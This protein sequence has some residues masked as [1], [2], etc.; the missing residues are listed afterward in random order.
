[1]K[2]TTPLRRRLRI[3]AI[4]AVA[5][6]PLAFAGLYVAA[7]GNASSGVSDIPAAVVNQDTMVTTTGTD[8]SPQYT[9]A[10]RAL[11]TQL[12][13][14][15]SPGMDWTIT[16]A[17]DAKKMLADGQVYAVLTIPPD[18]SKS[19]LSLRGT[20]P[21]VAKLSIRTDDAHSYLA[22]SVAQSLGDGMTRAFGSTITQQYV[23]GLAAG[24]GELSGSLTQAAGAAGQ[25]S[26][27][28]SSLS[29]GA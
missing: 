24:I 7:L 12:T 19:V 25:L 28:A 17:A 22:G 13:G 20:D 18:F 15:K 23:A 4:A 10:G 21:V 9:L 6:V 14:T 8:G 2:I 1:M 5:L 3:A 26:T 29:T 16:N 27:G 11:V